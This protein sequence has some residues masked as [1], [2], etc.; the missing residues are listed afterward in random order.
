MCC[1][2]IY[3]LFIKKLESVLMNMNIAIPTAIENI[4]I[5]V[6][7]WINSI[8]LISTSELHMGASSVVAAD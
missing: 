8:L 6:L 3:I 2:F 5:I 1:I 4:A 7:N